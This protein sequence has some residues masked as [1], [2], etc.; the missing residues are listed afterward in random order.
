MKLKFLSNET[1]DDQSDDNM[2]DSRKS[3]LYDHSFSPKPTHNE[4]KIS[5]EFLKQMCT[6][7]F[8]NIQRDFP[9]KFVKFLEA[10]KQLS[11]NGLQQLLA[12]SAGICANGRKHIIES[13]PFIGSVASVELMK[14][15]ITG[16]IRSTELTPEVEEIW[17]NSIFYLPR[18]EESTITSIFS[19]MQHYEVNHNP[20]FILIPS[21]VVHTFCKFNDCKNYAI[22]MNSIKYLEGIANDKLRGD[23]SDKQTYESLLVALKGLGNI[24]IVS[25][26]FE[27][28]LKDLIIDEYQKNDVKL[29]AIEVFRKTNCDNTRDFFVDIYQNMTQSVEIRIAS[30]VSIFAL[31]TSNTMFH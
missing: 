19:L 23:L 13:L 7:G 6:L 4:I 12:R 14:D 8:P 21:A 20:I 26:K 5:R 15:L 10:S 25:K 16:V 17:M 22:V 2:I 27:A 24:G 28:D 1:Y 29:Q 31:N 18:P 3:M 9:D 30:Y 11:S